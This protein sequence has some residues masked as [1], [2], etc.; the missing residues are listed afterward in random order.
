M[1]VKVLLLAALMLLMPSLAAAEI[2]V[3]DAWVRM[4]PPVADT[5]AGYL[6]LK[7]SGDHDVEVVSVESDAATKP[8][9]HSMSMH[10]GMMHM[11]KMDKV[12]IPAH[13]EL[14]FESG[15]NHLMLTGLARPLNAGDHVMLTIKTAD[16]GSVM[17]HAEVRDVRMKDSN[18]SDHG[19]HHH[20]H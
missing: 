13:G 16:G 11:M 19:G 17:V 6:T 2:T 9:F 10:D 8:E 5:A 14:K 20:G 1:K 12:I 4:P 7:N 15:G 3:E 18:D